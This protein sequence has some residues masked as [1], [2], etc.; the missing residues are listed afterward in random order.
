MMVML[1]VLWQVLV[2]GVVCVG[3]RL[4]MGY[5]WLL[6]LLV[7]VMLVVLFQMMLLGWLL[8]RLQV[9]VRVVL[10]MFVM[11][12]VVMLLQSLLLS[13]IVQVWLLM[14]LIWMEFVFCWLVV[15]MVLFREVY[16]LK[17]RVLK[18][19]VLL[20]LML[21]VLQV[22][23]SVVFRMMVVVCVFVGLQLSR[24]SSFLVRQWFRFIGFFRIMLFGV[25]FGGVFYQVMVISRVLVQVFVVGVGVFCLVGIMWLQRG[26]LIV[27][28]V[29]IEE[30]FIGVLVWISVLCVVFEQMLQVMVLL[31]VVVFCMQCWLLLVCRFVFIVRF[32]VR[33]VLYWIWI[34]L[35]VLMVCVLIMLVRLEWLLKFRVFY[36]LILLLMLLLMMVQLVLMI[37]CMLIW[38]I[39]VLVVWVVFSRLVQVQNNKIVGV[40]LFIFNFLLIMNVGGVG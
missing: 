33:L 9:R 21:F 5:Y 37:I 35:L 39:S 27:V 14:Y 2:I 6:L 13:V 30:M 15:L 23:S 32:G 12:C 34:L 10:V 29:E 19:I 38:L 28:L 11:C 3:I 20:L 7:V 22:G 1:M 16:W 4:Q 31:V 18:V 25:V 17:L 36:W 40:C 8:Y 24:Q 26:M